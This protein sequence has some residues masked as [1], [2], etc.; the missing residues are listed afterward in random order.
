MAIDD[1]TML[2]VL[3]GVLK[4]MTEATMMTTRLMVFPTAWVTGLT[5]G[6]K[7]IGCVRNR[8][9]QFQRNLKYLWQNTYLSEGK[10]GN[11][12]VRIVRSTTKCKKC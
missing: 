2:P 12:V 9:K 10:E 4:A 3:I 1:P 11:L 6:R 5:Y 7:V 8:H